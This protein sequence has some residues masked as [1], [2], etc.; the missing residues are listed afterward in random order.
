MR[1]KWQGQ[2]A[3]ASRRGETE[4]QNERDKRSI[5]EVLC[6]VGEDGEELAVNLVRLPLD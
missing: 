5:T 2:A 6:S 3:E 1:D 4:G